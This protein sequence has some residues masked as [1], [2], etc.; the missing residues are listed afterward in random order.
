MSSLIRY[1]SNENILNMRPA[2]KQKSEN[3]D[4]ILFQIEKINSMLDKMD[5]ELRNKDYSEEM[6]VKYDSLIQEKKKL[7]KSMRGNYVELMARPTC[8]Q[9]G[10]RLFHC[11]R[12]ENAIESIIKEGIRFDVAHNFID[13]DMGKGL[14]CTTDTPSYLSTDFPTAIVFSVAQDLKAVITKSLETHR[15]EKEVDY[16]QI[17]EGYQQL[18]ETYPALV[19]ESLHASMSEILLLNPLKKIRIIGIIDEQNSSPTPIDVWMKDR[20]LTVHSS[21]L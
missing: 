9:A 7:V 8:L 16:T 20:K 13:P 11:T 14:Y 19:Q 6:D 10:L 5:C 15:F 12:G 2:K 18:K 21:W 17:N 3:D 1:D 4:L